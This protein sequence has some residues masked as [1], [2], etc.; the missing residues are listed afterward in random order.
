[1]VVN[2]VRLTALQNRTAFKHLESDTIPNCEQVKLNLGHVYGSLTG[3]ISLGSLR[4]N[5]CIYIQ[6]DDNTG[7]VNIFS[8]GPSLYRKTNDKAQ[9]TIVWKSVYS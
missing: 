2:T 6:F 5:S 8:G 9:V 7:P 1:M 3:Q 4:V